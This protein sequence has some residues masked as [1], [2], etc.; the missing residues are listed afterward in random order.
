MHNKPQKCP[1]STGANQP[2]PRDFACPGCGAEV[3]I[4]SDEMQAICPS[5]GR[6]VFAETVPS[7]VLW[8][9]SAQEC[10]GGKIDVAKLRAAHE[11]NTDPL[12]NKHRVEEIQAL[13]RN[14]R[15]KNK[16]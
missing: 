2:H 16:K 5:C 15:H 8:C 14:C 13:I 11:K 7:C 9:P 6:L 1:G 3:E 12:E 4:W 10:L